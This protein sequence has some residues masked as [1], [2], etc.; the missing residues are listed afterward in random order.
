M[1]GLITNLNL[2]QRTSINMIGFDFITGVELGFELLSGD[3]IVT[4]DGEE[5]NWAVQ[6]SLFLV[7]ITIVSF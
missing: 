7:R 6:I 3:S 1:S 2:L 5:A 4:E